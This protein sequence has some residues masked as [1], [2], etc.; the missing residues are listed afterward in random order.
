MYI[1]IVNNIGDIVKMPFPM[2]AVT[3]NSK[4]EDQE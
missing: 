3:V 4:E 2:K 1:W